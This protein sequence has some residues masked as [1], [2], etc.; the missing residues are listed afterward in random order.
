MGGISKHDEKIVF[1]RRVFV[2]TS[3]RFRFDFFCLPHDIELKFFRRTHKEQQKKATP[4]CVEINIKT[5]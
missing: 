2:F 5:E 3:A 1:D 4:F